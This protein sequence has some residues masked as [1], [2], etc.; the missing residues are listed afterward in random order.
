MVTTRSS[1]NLVLSI[2]LICVFSEKVDFNLFLGIHFWTFI[3]VH[4][5]FFKKRLQKPVFYGIAPYVTLPASSALGAIFT[6]RFST[7]I[8]SPSST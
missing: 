7:S 1:K 8:S 5:P 3:N 6:F 2:M 4:F